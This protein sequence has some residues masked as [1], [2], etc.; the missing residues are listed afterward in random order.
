LVNYKLLNKIVFNSIYK[1]NHWNKSKKF[2][3]NQ[4]YSGPGSVANSI[5]T[6]NLILELQKFF[7][8]NDIKNILDAPCG[9]CAWIKKIFE[10]DI[11]Y[12]GIDIVE[13]LINQNKLTFNSNLNIKFYCEDLTEYKNFNNYDFILLRDFFIHLPLKMINKILKNL[14][15]SNCR[16]FAFNNYESANIN[17]EISIGQ[18]RKINILKDPFNLGLPYYKI[19]EINNKHNPDQ[20]NYIYIYKN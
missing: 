6:N 12:T 13:D 9:D 18:H 7:K 15:N 20:D 4:S 1:S 8:E 5:Q 11:N 19:Q 3:S 10:T 14:K 17:K 16:F 2:D